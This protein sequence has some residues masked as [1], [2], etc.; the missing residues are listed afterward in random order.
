M[1]KIIF[2][3]LTLVLLF[4]SCS[5][6]DVY[7]GDWKATN[8]EGAHADIHFEEKSMWITHADGKKS[9]YEYTQNEVKNENGVR[10]FGIKLGD[11]RK[12]QMYFPLTEDSSKGL[13]LDANNHVLYTISRDTY[14]LYNDLY[15]L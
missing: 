15:A 1:K 14:L 6:S 11:G 10:T 12:L 2:P 8:M 4:A 13:I 7:R 9:E 5:G 3:L